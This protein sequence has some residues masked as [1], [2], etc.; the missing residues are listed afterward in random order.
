MVNEAGAVDAAPAGETAARGGSPLPVVGVGASA[1]GLAATTDLLRHLGPQPG[2]AVV[3]VHHLDP[4]HESSLAEIISRVTPLPV[5]A[6]AD[7][8]EVEPDRIYV[9]PQNAILGMRGGA[10]TLRPRTEEGHHLPID[11]F[12]ESLAVDRTVQPL[13]VVLTGAGSDGTEGIKAI[14]THGGITFAQDGSAEY[15]SMP[16]SAIAT[17][18]VDFILPPTGAMSWR[19][20]RRV[21]SDTSS[22]TRHRKSSSRRCGPWPMT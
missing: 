7:G 15:G 22:R 3:I 21:R 18:C 12:F 8:L 20:S 2:V 17:G 14:K 4:T 1:G 16:E 9:V 19:C 6:A 5:R 13:G 10:L 11:R